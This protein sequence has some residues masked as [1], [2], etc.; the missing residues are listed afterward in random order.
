MRGVHPQ[1]FG[2]SSF[3]VIENREEI[4]LP[5]LS[6]LHLPQKGYQVLRP[7]MYPVLHEGHWS[8]ATMTE[9]RRLRWLGLEVAGTT[10]ELAVAS[11]QG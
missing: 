4:I 2:G 7:P 1:G 3:W 10:V 9:E 11:A 6:E 8:A 5:M